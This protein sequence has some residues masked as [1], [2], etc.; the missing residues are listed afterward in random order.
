MYY[1][2]KDEKRKLKNLLENSDPG[3]PPACYYSEKKN[4]LIRCWKSD[5]KN[6]RYSWH[7]K[8]YHRKYRRMANK[9]GYAISKNVYDLWWNMY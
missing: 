1:R 2:K 3:Y 5:G 8:Q 6:S 7:K 9:V 4:R